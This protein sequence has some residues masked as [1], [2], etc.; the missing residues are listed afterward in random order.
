MAKDSTTITVNDK[1]VLA[2]LKKGVLTESDMLDIEA[3]IGLTVVN[4]QREKVPV[5]TSATQ[6]SIKPDIQKSSKDEVV[7]HIGPSTDYAPSIEFGIT[8]KPNYPIQPFVRPSI[9]GNE[10]NIFNVA[11]EAFKR[12]IRE[13]WPI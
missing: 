7:D 12:K 3:P 2:A 10:R 5:L 1:E 6:N 13:K 8:S 4:K 9:F 11:T